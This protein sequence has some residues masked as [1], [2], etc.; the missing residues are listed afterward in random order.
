MR[1]KRIYFL[2]GIFFLIAAICFFTFN[3]NE[4]TFSKDCPFCQSFILDTNKFYED[5]LVMA[6]CTH[7]PIMPGHCLVIPKRHIERF[8]MLSDDEALQ[9]FQV[10]RKVDLAAKKAF[11]TSA[12]LLWQKNGREVGQTV[13]HV[14]FHYIPRKTGDGSV[15]KFIL[16]MF[17]VNAQKPIESAE[18][19]K[20]VEKMKTAMNEPDKNL[21]T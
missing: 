9:I 15:L 18:I 19:Q 12:Y 7:K 4:K 10:I 17:L 20:A 5:D 11:G 8:E 14:H 1:K 3:R 2:L 21:R 13:P 6:L 16:K